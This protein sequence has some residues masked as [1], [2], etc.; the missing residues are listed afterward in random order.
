MAD[1]IRIEYVK[2]SPHTIV[3]KSCAGRF[4]IGRASCRSYDN[5]RYLRDLCPLASE[6]TKNNTCFMDI[7]FKHASSLNWFYIGGIFRVDFRGLEYAAI[8]CFTQSNRLTY[9]TRSC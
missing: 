6:G 3:S 2:N 9:V 5:A 4:Y 7:I 1:D 8:W